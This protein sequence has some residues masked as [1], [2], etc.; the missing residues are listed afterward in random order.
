MPPIYDKMGHV[1][2]LL[3][4]LM[5]STLFLLGGLECGFFVFSFLRR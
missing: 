1:N 3:T 5:V 4:C 2:N